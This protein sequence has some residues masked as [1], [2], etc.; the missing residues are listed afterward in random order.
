[1]GSLTAQMFT[2][3]DGVVQ[4]PGDPEEDRSG[5][6]RH[7][8]WHLPFFEPQGQEWVVAAHRAADAFL[9]GRRT[10]EVF[11]RYWPHATE[12]E[13]GELPELLNGKP[14]YVVG[15]AEVDAW[16]PTTRLAGPLEEAV[17]ELLADAGDVLVIGSAAL[18]RSLLDLDLVDRMRLMVDPVSIGGGV[19]M[20]P[21]T[22]ARRDWTLAGH[23]V[24][25]NGV[26]LLGYDRARP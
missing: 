6:F 3:L 5:G 25:P 9:F 16:G 4:A 2:T 14:K 7:G 1:M 17:P 23:A 12:A 18:T 15:G 10:F 19:R 20:F 22:G 21:E 11:A 24:T 8:G 26:L 13:A